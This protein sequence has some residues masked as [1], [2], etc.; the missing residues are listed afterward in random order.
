MRLRIADDNKAKLKEISVYFGGVDC[1]TMVNLILESLDIGSTI[2]EAEK[3]LHSK[4]YT[5]NA[6]NE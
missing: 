1:T 2:K 5:V 3:L 4:K 6:I